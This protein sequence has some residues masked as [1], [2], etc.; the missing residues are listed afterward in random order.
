MPRDRGAV[1]NLNATVETM[2]SHWTT[3]RAVQKAQM[4]S[5]LHEQHALPTFQYIYIYIYATIKNC[6]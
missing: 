1:D 5:L 4:L 2:F 3:T 6:P